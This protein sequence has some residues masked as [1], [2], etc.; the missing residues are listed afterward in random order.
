[1]DYTI[2]IIDTI[3]NTHVLSVENALAKSILLRYNGGDQKDELFIVGS[4]LEFTLVH[5]ELTDAK[6]GDLFTGDEKRYKIRLYKTIE[7]VTV[8]SGFLLPDSYGEPYTN[9]V[10]VSRFEASD[11][12]GRLRGKYLPDAFYKEEQSVIDIIAN[13]LMLTDLEL[14][15]W[16]TPAIENTSV[17]DYDVI[18]INTVNFLNNDK[19]IDA[20][21]ILYTLLHD[22]MCTCYQADDRWYVEGMNQRHAKT[23]EFK[24]YTYQGVYVSTENK[25]RLIKSITPLATPM[26]TMI[27]PY[28]KITVTRDLV[29]KTLPKTIYNEN[30]DGWTITT[31]VV[32]E[33]YPTDWNSNNFIALSTAPDYNLILTSTATGV[34]DEA[35]YIDLKKKIYVERGDK[36][37][38]SIEFYNI[39]AKDYSY[40]GIEYYIDKGYWDNFLTFKI[41]IN[42]SF[43]N[44]ETLSVNSSLEAKSEF[45]ILVETTGLLDI[46][47]VQPYGVHFST[48][49]I[50]LKEIILEQID[51]KENDSVDDIINENFTIDKDVPLTFAD[52]R[53]AFAK[54]FQLAK[55]NTQ[56]LNYTEISVAVLYGFTQNSTNYSVVGLAGCNLIADN[57][58]FVYYSGAL[59]TGLSTIYN[60]ANGE[61]MVVVT[62]TPITSGSFVV[63]VY[64]YDDY[65]TDRTVWT[66]WSDSIYKIEKQKYIDVVKNIYRRLFAVQHHK[67]D[68]IVKNAI[69]FNDMVRF[70][71]IQPNNYIVTNSVW[72]L[73]SGE[74]TLSLVKAFYQNDDASNPGSNLPP[75]VIALD[76]FELTASQT[77]ANLTSVVSAPD[78]T[79]VTILW[80][81]L[82]GTNGT[83]TTPA[84]LDTGLTNLTDDD[85][86]YQITVTDSNGLSASDIVNITRVINY[87]ISLT[88]ISE[89]TDTNTDQGIYRIALNPNLPADYS[90]KL[91]GTYDVITNKYNQYNSSD[92]Y[93]K[94]KKN[95]VY[96]FDIQ[97]N[98][99]VTYQ[100]GTFEFNII[101]TDVIDFELFAEASVDDVQSDQNPSAEVNMDLLNY[102]FNAGAG[103]ITGLPLSKTVTITIV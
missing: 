49:E 45:D 79:I 80:E 100:N 11:G 29:T 37:K 58:D 53:S 51:P 8:W 68:L 18:F 95:G 81:K 13:C 48:H 1:M 84:A 59:L 78:G 85:Y 74:T 16:F 14:D 88:T 34:I 19:Q 5:N 35:K 91:S 39:K 27:P 63:R 96:I 54:S 73:D 33:I 4:S 66:Q 10:V 92:A 20:Y 2:D 23:L 6:Y 94:I 24:K 25:T 41:L 98:G 3:D 99:D 67:I 70:R 36:F 97:G 86:K 64:K 57:I 101:S 43:I 31:G 89:S 21:N 65:I 44:G 15:I 26:V 61:Q 12:L 103:T 83:I 9:N 102:V 32:G 55:L 69:K 75:V 71:Y 17:K 7:N 46:V 28:N 72:D 93:F 30:N 50:Q 77:T 52:D 56:T 90:V 42:G 47:I 40:S 62:P 22:M 38:F 76:D 82:I 87:I 60:Y